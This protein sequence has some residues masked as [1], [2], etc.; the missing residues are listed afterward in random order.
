MGVVFG[1]FHLIKSLVA[2]ESWNLI[3]LNGSRCVGIV[4]GKLLTPSSNIYNKPQIFVSLRDIWEEQELATAAF[5]PLSPVPHFL[6]LP[7]ERR[8]L[9]PNANGHRKGGRGQWEVGLQ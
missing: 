5:C 6:V 1:T 9:H 8:R 3:K 2:G 4:T 7:Q